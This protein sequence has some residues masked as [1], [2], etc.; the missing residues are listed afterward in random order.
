M[1]TKGKFAPNYR[2][3][4]SVKELERLANEV[5]MFKHPTCPPDLSTLLR[6]KNIDI[7]YQAVTLKKS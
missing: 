2:K 4:D 5:A 3:P 6:Q 7:V 1:R